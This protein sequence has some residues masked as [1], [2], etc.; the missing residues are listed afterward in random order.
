MPNTHI[1]L[2]F[3]YI[4][5]Y[6]FATF[7]HGEPW[8]SSQMWLLLVLKAARDPSNYDVDV[9]NARGRARARFCAL[10]LRPLY[11]LTRDFDKC[12]RRSKRGGAGQRGGCNRGSRSERTPPNTSSSF[13]VASFSSLENREELLLRLSLFTSTAVMSVYDKCW[14]KGWMLIEKSWEKN[15]VTKFWMRHFFWENVIEYAMKGL[16]GQFRT[17]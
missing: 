3:L 17:V 10:Q 15:C 9:D 4:F 5:V 16:F 8:Y 12:V 1:S 7:Q 2:P 13:C 6:F 14:L 11:A